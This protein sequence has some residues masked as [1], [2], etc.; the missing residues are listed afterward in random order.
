MKA[1]E[2]KDADKLYKFSDFKI[3]AYDSAGYVLQMKIGNTICSGEQFRE[4]LSLPSSSFSIKD[5]KGELQIKTNGNG[6]G[7][8]MSQWTANQMAKEGKSYRG[9]SAVFL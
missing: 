1:V 8:G 5:V 6:H 2:E 4:A 7:L 3:E 9:N